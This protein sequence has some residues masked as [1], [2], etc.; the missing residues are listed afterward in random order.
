MRVGRAC[1]F[2]PGSYRR[3][4]SAPIGTALNGDGGPGA[5]TCRL[6]LWRVIHCDADQGVA[7]RSRTEAYVPFV[8]L[9]IIIIIII[10]PPPSSR[11]GARPRARLSSTERMLPSKMFMM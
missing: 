11:L 7:S 5:A 9:I 10:I 1:G 6:P 3:R 2:V 8:T 4:Q